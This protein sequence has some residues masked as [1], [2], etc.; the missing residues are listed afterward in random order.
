MKG[1]REE[2][3]TKGTN[4]GASSG[5]EGGAA[6]GILRKACQSNHPDRWPGG[7]EERP[8]GGGLGHKVT[9]ELIL[10]NQSSE[11]KTNRCQLGVWEEAAGSA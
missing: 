4:K 8:W 11:S 6:Y 7:R 2:G 5:I 10:Q 1:R 3:R 9:A